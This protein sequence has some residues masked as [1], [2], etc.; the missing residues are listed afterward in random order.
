MINLWNDSEICGQISMILKEHWLYTFQ[1]SAQLL[2]YG[3]KGIDPN[4]KLIEVNHC[5]SC[6]NTH[7]I[8]RMDS[9]IHLKLYYINSA[10]VLNVKR[11]I[12][13]SEEIGKIIVDIRECCGGDMMLVYK[14][15]HKIRFSIY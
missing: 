15:G 2:L 5:S 6:E 3:A 10:V 9:I 11:F 13:E 7:S 8:K 12:I 4:L 14:Y 1:E